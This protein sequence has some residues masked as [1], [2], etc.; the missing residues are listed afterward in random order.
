[1][2]LVRGYYKNEDGWVMLS[3]IVETI[4][5]GS[6][7]WYDIFEVERRY[8]RERVNPNN[9]IRVCVRPVRQRVVYFQKYSYFYTDSRKSG[10][11]EIQ[12]I[13]RRRAWHFSK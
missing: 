8:Q 11:K 4:L 12:L 3:Q 6:W 2:S 7:G 9:P 10:V 13:N 5:Q 1:M